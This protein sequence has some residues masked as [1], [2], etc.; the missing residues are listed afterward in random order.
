MGPRA[1]LPRLG[2]LTFN[3]YAWEFLCG[4]VKDLEYQGKC[5]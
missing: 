4:W 2:Y 1:F 3:S 5:S